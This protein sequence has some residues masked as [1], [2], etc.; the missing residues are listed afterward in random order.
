MTELQ[1]TINEKIF[2]KSKSRSGK[3]TFNKKLVGHIVAGIVDNQVAIGYSLLHRNDMY[4]VVNGQRRPGH[5]KSLAFIRAQKWINNEAV[6]VPPSIAKQVRK[7]VARCE[8]YYKDAH[9]QSVNQM[10]V[11]YDFPLFAPEA[12]TKGA[13]VLL[14]KL[15]DL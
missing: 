8:R 5:G 12:L 11:E 15:A 7:F 13:S 6:V 14:G 4:D 2:K 10:E 3:T 9:I 1:N